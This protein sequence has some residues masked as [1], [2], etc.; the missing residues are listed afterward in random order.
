ML[1]KTPLP[2]SNGKPKGRSAKGPALEKT[3]TGI[4][5]LD[6]ITEGGL[7]KGRP[8]LLC[9]STGCG[10]TLMAVQFIYKG[11]LDYNEP[12]VIMTFEESIEDLSK[13][14]KSLG[15][16]LKKLIA[17]K[18]LRVDHVK[19]ERSEIEE[20]GEYDLEGLFIRL[21]HAIDSIG[22]KRVMLDT[23]ESLF[24]GFDN[25]AILRSEIRR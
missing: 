7:P 8:T 1:K 15:V 23:L 25:A 11:I 5:G 4:D 6:E 24:S 16:D 20:T 18:M 9:G 17:D 19:V 13:N 22:A 14:V 10:K 12:G 3:Q 21:G 2:K